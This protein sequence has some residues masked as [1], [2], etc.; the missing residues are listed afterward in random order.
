MVFQAERLSMRASALMI[1]TWRVLGPDSLIMTNSNIISH[2]Q[3]MRWIPDEV[4]DFSEWC[5][6]LNNVVHFQVEA[7]P[8]PEGYSLEEVNH[9]EGDLE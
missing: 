5:D 3:Q 4:R 9:G 6:M 8:V 1:P 7:I 2:L